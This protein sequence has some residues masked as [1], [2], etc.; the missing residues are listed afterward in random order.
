MP[1]FSKT[2]GKY[3]DQKAA[4]EFIYTQDQLFL[5]ISILVVAPLE[6]DDSIFKLQNAI[7]GDGNPVGIA[8][9]VF[10]HVTGIFEGRF[11]VDN[12]FLPV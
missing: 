6:C 1:D 10:N 3:V 2:V 8:S 7:V 4:D 5:L 9:E 12:P 11:A